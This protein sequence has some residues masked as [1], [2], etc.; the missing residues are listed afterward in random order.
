MRM[1]INDLRKIDKN[2]DSTKNQRDL[3]AIYI[4]ITEFLTNAGGREIKSC[5]ES[6]K[7]SKALSPLIDKLINMM[8][9][10]ER[11]EKI[12]RDFKRQFQLQKDYLT[13]FHNLVE[14]FLQIAFDNRYSINKN[15]VN[16]L[17]LYTD[18]EAQLFRVFNK[19]RNILIHSNGET[20]ITHLSENFLINTV[21]NIL[22]DCSDFLYKLFKDYENIF[23]AKY[24][25][26][27]KF[28]TGLQQA[29]MGKSRIKI[30]KD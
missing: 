15:L 6:I 9:R 5:E 3:M 23:M 27:K 19:Y 29:N 25:E 21:P 24:T 12:L 16:I 14:M 10:N 26:G 8:N 4:Y 18:E 17:N 2:F 20:F 11:N 22:K 7:S 1:N 28:A 30:K 13:H